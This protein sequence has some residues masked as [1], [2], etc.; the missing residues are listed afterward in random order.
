MKRENSGPAALRWLTFLVLLWGSAS[1]AQELVTLPGS[2][3]L[4]DLAVQFR[5]GAAFDPLEAPGTA[6][7][8]AQSLSQAAT[9][10]RSYE[11]VLQELYPW[12]VEVRTTV[13]KEVITF[14][15]TVHRDHLEPFTS[16]WVEMLTAP[17]FDASDLDRLR[18]QAKNFLTQDLRANNDEELGKEALR[19]LLFPAGHPYGR[20]NVGTLTGLDR[21]RPDGVRRFYQEQ[22]H[23]G[24]VTLGVAG[25]YPAGYPER[26]QALLQQGLPAAPEG[27]WESPT[28]PPAAPPDG[29]R[30]T[31]IE[32]DTRSVAMSLGFPI[33]VHRAHP[34]WTALHLIRSFLGEHRSS[35]SHLYQ[36]L[37]E[38][39]G[40]NYGDYAYIEY[41]PQGMF[42][43]QPPAYHPRRHQIFEIWIR[44]VQPEN[45]LFTLRATLF[46]L[47]RLVHQGLTAEQFEATRSFLM[48]NSPLQVAA[49]DRRLGYALDSQF[50]EVEPY[51]ER[52]RRELPELTLEQVN[53]ALRRHL[54]ADRLEIVWVAKE[55]QKLR[56]ELTRGAPSP[57][58]YNSPKPDE[59]LA[60]DRVIANF[61]LRLDEVRIVPLDQMFR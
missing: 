44:P 20:H 32:K 25:G 6:Y 5:T 58:T 11:Q 12:G 10:S 37:R 13:D 34:D 30:L 41:F 53:E 22:M 61:P 50:Y 9:Q 51:L 28:I 33:E 17:K 60:E 21:V 55:A 49:S 4:V 1:G 29:R 3:P 36:R 23:S 19:W 45:A 35:N 48:K 14:S 7:L 15:A 42:S 27:R 47:E 40:L 43:F 39:R 18:D 26:L 57:I 59:V 16:L 24:A 46:E 56:A 31:I 8:T 38:A 52:L 2:S 54:Q